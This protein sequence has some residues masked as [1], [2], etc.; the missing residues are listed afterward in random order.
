MSGKMSG[1]VSGKIVEL[2]LEDQGITIPE[3][4]K[5]L[6]RT[7]RTVERLINRLKAE[8]IIGRIGPAKGGHWEV[9]K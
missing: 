8:E 4:A 5:R 3:L 9:L 1:I 2:M 6:K 7:E